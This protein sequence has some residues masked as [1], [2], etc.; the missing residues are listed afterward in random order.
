MVEQI[1]EVIEASN[2]SRLEDQKRSS[3][4]VDVEVPLNIQLELS[5]SDKGD[6]SHIL[7]NL[8]DPPNLQ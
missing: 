7:Q 8:R 4:K 5:S 2:D 1:A 6:S 3:K